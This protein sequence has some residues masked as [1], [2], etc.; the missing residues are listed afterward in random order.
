MTALGSLKRLVNAQ[1]HRRG[2]VLAHAGVVPSFERLVQLLRKVN[3][4]PRTVID[5]GIAEG[6]P[7]LYE[8]FPCAKFFLVDPTRESLHYMNAWAAKIDAEIYNVALGEIES[9]MLID[10]RDKIGGSS[11]FEE[12]GPHRSIDRYLVPVRRFDGVMGDFDRPALCKIDV[13][14]AELLVLRGMGE[15]VHELDAIVVETSLIATIHD[16]PV[17]ADVISLMQE[18]QFSLYDIV[19]VTRRPLDDAMAQVDAVFVPVN[20]PLR[21]DRRWTNRI[22]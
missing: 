12:I 22:V 8:A 11:L 10:V 4:E 15:R 9:E 5:I 13:Q 2:H 1:L 19:G 6:T 16:G 17:I 18:L 21:S 14:G 3:L 7:W 20:S